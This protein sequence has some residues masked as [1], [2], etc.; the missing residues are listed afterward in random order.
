MIKELTLQDF[1]YDLPSHL[2]A[3][4]P[5]R[6]RD[7]SRL[8]VLHREDGRMEDRVF[9][10]LPLYLE[11]GDLLILNDTKVIPARL[12]GRR[13]T[14][15]RRE[16]LLLRPCEGGWRCLAKGGRIREGERIDFGKGLSGTVRGREGGM[17]VVEF[18]CEGPFLKVL[19]QVG[20]V[21]LPP[22]IKR[23]DD[24]AD[25][26]R[27]QTVYA[28]SPGAVAAPTAGLHFTIE[29]LE[30]IRERG[31]RV[32]TVTLHVGWGTFKPLKE[33]DIVRGRLHGEEYSIPASVAEAVREAR[34][35]GRRIFATGTTVTRALETAFSDPDNPLLKGE[36]DLFIMPGYRF[37]VVDALITN[38]HLPR[39]S[40]LLLVSALAGRDLIMEAYKRAI[41]KGY[42]F[43][44]YGDAMLIL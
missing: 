36:S 27:Y 1:D 10:D 41:E 43:Y 33:E 4:F 37:R 12:I 15:G 20:R 32:E 11:E 3:Q 18:H 7:A 14:G 22:Y 34:E 42:R 9:S 8:M 5:S 24:P 38:F 31:V 19:E 21:P 40:P 35:K 30:A 16:F 26:Q 25:R 2:I 28:R 17:W 29:L 23:I 6:R 39:S 13:T 44:S